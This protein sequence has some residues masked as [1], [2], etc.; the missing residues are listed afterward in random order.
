MLRSLSLLLT[1]C[2]GIGGDDIGVCTVEG[3]GGTKGPDDPA[4]EAGAKI[5]CCGTCALGASGG[6]KAPFGAIAVLA[7]E[8]VMSASGDGGPGGCPSFGLCVMPPFGEGGTKIGC[9]GICAFGAGGLP[10]GE[11]D[12]PDNGKLT[13]GRADDCIV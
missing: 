1:D 4:G 10:P 7:D 8:L 9:V 2:F 6:K 11:S 5:G 13:S 3:V 12:G